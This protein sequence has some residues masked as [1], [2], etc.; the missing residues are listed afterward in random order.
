[1]TDIQKIEV[2]RMRG[3]YS[4]FGVFSAAGGD[5]TEVSLK[6]IAEKVN[7]IIEAINDK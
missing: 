7:E 4:E 5:D 2:E 1:M 3:E 6:K